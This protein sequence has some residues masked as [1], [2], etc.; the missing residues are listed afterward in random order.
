[1]MHKARLR[2]LISAGAWLLIGCA[3]PLGNAIERG[4][5]RSAKA[6]LDQGA[7]VNQRFCVD[8]CGT[9]LA[10]AASKG[11]LA[12][13]KLLLDRGAELDRSAMGQAAHAGYLE[14]VKLL[15]ERGASVNEGGPLVAA[16][17][18]GHP[19]IVRFLI[20]RGAD[21]N[22]IDGMG[23]TPLHDA[24]RGDTE[25]HT[26]VIRLLL[27]QG[28]DWRAKDI[29]QRTPL[30]RANRNNH[31]SLR[32]LRQAAASEL[33]PARSQLALSPAPKPSVTSDVDRPPAMAPH[34]ARRAYAI[35]VGIEEY[36]QHLP[37]ADFAA[38][39]AE[40]MRDYL[41]K[42]FGYP[43]Q[44]VV[45]VLNER[46]TKTSL[47]KYVDGWLPDHVEKG[48]SVF[49]YFSGHGAPNPKTGKAYL[50]PFD[51]DPAFIERTGYPLDKLY[52]S[53]GSLLAK[54]V[55]VVLDSCFSGAGGRSVIAEGARPM[56]L[57][58]E[59]PMLTKGRVVVLAAS[60]GA[61]ISS[62]YKQQGHGLL[63]YYFLKG[64]H[65]EA[66]QNQDKA[67]DLRELYDYLRLQ[68][69]RTARRDF[70]NEQT[71]QLLGSP[72][73]LDRLWLLGPMTP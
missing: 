38:H 68:V 27:E 12:M 31:E 35:V 24:A 47:E 3:S 20:D 64:L 1:M 29:N 34:P 11:N 58:V 2:V 61:Q 8:S 54:D 28:A 55:F 33:A 4:D 45:M 67:T 23:D 53:L 49:V 25:G 26:A 42:T 52:D 37:K 21:V 59:N 71:P 66:D 15:L 48:D 46:A 57:S 7:N 6:L 22:G 39:D 32:L 30:E 65:G 40:I 60:T 14:I 62:T 16:A 51:G 36:Q 10:V 63:T 19:E 56:V 50:V 73:T 9:P 17:G 18:G 13:V 41:I 43:E 72:E 69:E 44:N 70:H 5:V